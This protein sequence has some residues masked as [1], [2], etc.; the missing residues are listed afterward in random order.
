MSE[1]SGARFGRAPRPDSPVAIDTVVVGAGQAGL[2]LSHHLSRAGHGH[3]L[4]ERGRVG[5]RWHERWDSLTLLSANWMNLLPGVATP[6]DPDGFLSR[7]DVIEHLEAYARSFGAP[8]VEGVDVTR[9]ERRG[10]SF[11]VET[12]SGTWLARNVVVA[13]GDAADPYVPFA[14]PREVASLHSADYRRPDLLPDGPVLV[15]GAGATGS[16]SHSSSP[17]PG[18]RSSSRSVVIRALRV[19]TAAATSSTGSSCS[20]TST[21]RSTSCPT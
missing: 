16:S 17:P 1:T 3:V 4:L 13:T 9:I 15:V 7:T 8:V 6:G 10:A 18:E 11:R 21:S 12:T 5:Q 20:V 19:G 14:A 2:A